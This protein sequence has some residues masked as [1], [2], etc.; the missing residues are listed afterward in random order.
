MTAPETMAR[1]ARGTVGAR[2]ERDFLGAKSGMVKKISD[3]SDQRS[4]GGDQQPAISDQESRKAVCRGW[5]LISD[6]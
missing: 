4:G 6:N 3:I 1:G 5:F 2:G